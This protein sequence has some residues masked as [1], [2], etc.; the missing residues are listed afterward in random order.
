MRY[1]SILFEYALVFLRLGANSSPMYETPNDVSVA[2]FGGFGGGVGGVTATAGADAGTPEGLKYVKNIG[3]NG[4]G[5]L[6]AQGPTTRKHSGN[7]GITRK[8]TKA[9]PFDP[10]EGAGHVGLAGMGTGAGFGLG[11]GQGISEDAGEDAEFRMGTSAYENVGQ[12]MSVSMPD[13]SV[14]GPM[15]DFGL[16]ATADAGAGIGAGFDSDP[17]YAQVRL[18]PPTATATVGGGVAAPAVSVKP[19][20]VNLLTKP[21]FHKK[22]VP[23]PTASASV[24]VPSVSTSATGST[25]GVNLGVSGPST[26][27]GFGVGLSGPS[28]S[29]GLRT[30]GPSTGV[31]IGVS[32][33]TGVGL[34]G[35]S[36]SLG[37]RTSGPSTGEGIGVGVSE[38]STTLGIGVGAAGPSVKVSG[39]ALGTASAKLKGGVK[40]KKPNFFQ[41]LFARLGGGGAK[42]KG[43]SAGAG[44]SVSTPA[45]NVQ[46]PS[47]DVVR[48]Y[49]LVCHCSYV[50]NSYVI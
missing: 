41:R 43:M 46:A 30:S 7:S 20:N 9:T 45:L 24:N 21:H 38:P 5:F 27:A 37:L 22:P 4:S 29:L 34:S 6:Q 19:G 28:T 39:P 44:M 26:G 1:V 15:P 18:I 17:S 12:N 3:A 47:A 2:P 36:T 11:L 50:M 8:S 16:G 48:N 35:P 31:G 23:L 10:G 33:S 42:R 14:S 25:P 32:G 13:L 49:S 40:V